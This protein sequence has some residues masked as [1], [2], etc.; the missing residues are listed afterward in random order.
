MAEELAFNERVG[1]GGAIDLDQRAFAAGAP[2]PRS[3]L[4]PKRLRSTWSSVRALVAMSMTPSWCGRPL[5]DRCGPSAG[6]GLVLRRWCT[7]FPAG[8]SAHDMTTTI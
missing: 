5:W 8:R 1:N 7:A 4:P 2:S 3:P 6:F